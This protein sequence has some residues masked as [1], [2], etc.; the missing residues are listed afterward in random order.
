MMIGT[1]T[2]WDMDA[3]LGVKENRLQTIIMLRL[4]MPDAYR[5][6]GAK[7]NRYTGTKG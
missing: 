5:N 3:T 6:S 7:E 1:F 2:K 4:H